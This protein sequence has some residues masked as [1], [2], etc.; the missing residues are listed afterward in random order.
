MRDNGRF[1]WLEVRRIFGFED[2]GALERE[3][4]GSVVTRQ[5]RHAGL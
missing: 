3:F 1:R 5:A 4:M 2:I